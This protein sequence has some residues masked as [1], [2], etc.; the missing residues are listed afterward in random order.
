VA[1]L[2]K[3]NQPEANGAGEDLLRSAFVEMLFALA[4]SQV[5]I[6]AADLAAVVAPWQAKMPAAAH[7]GVGL[8]VIAASWLGWRQSVSP[9]MKERVK[10]LFSVPFIGLLVDVFLVILYFI[11]V[12]NVEIEQQGGQTVL[13]PAT[14]RPESF[15][16]CVVFG[17]YAFWD[18]VA[19]VFSM[20]CI[21]KARFF[22]RV[23]KALRAACVSVFASLVCLLLSYSAFVVATKRTD[24]DEVLFLDGMLV[25][26]ILFFRAVKAFE[27]VLA[28]LLRVKDCKA[29]M[30]ARKTQGRELRWGILLLLLYAVCFLGAF[31]FQPR[32]VL[33]CLL[34]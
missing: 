6:N 32:E 13:A 22:P 1:N 20:G 28:P 7:L 27:N 14:A 21:P 16:L 18:L 25:C 17:V 29:F 19:D 2:A 11:I 33:R 31:D 23:W 5:A 26:V 3:P 24:A 4:A 12:R 10:Y 9:G 34:G 8:L 30:E 15:W